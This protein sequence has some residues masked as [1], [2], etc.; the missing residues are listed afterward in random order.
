[1]NGKKL[2]LILIGSAVLLAFGAGWFA[3]VRG[4]EEGDAAAKALKESIARG[5]AYFRDPAL[6]TN[7]KFCAECHENP[8]KPRLNLADRV[9]DYPKWDRREGS[10]ITLGQKIDQMIDRMLK[11]E[12]KEL[13]SPML[14]DLE[15]YLM[16][17]SRDR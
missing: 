10:V 14:V 6:G 17:I 4:E 16:S 12:K 5:K 11:G 7:E 13:G 2:R 15:A 3:P 9:N 1:M 8:D